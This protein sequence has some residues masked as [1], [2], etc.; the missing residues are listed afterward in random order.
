MTVSKNR[1]YENKTMSVHGMPGVKTTLAMQQNDFDPLSVNDGMDEIDLMLDQLENDIPDEVFEI[2]EFDVDQMM[3][4]NRQLRDKIRDISDMVITAITKASMLKKKIVSHRDEHKNPDM[5]DR[6]K[7]IN[8]YQSKIAVYKKKIRSLNFKVDNLTGA[9]KVLT[10]KSNIKTLDD[11]VAE[12]KKQRNVLASN[13]KHQQ[14][15]MN[16]LY[17]DP[18][19]REKMQKTRADIKA[20]KEK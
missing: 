14:D 10:H 15:T 8:D 12:L 3:K 20:I 16:K 5:R 1:G 11:E 17:D 19:F 7:E 6:M 9:D 2:E 18:D 4:N 13:I